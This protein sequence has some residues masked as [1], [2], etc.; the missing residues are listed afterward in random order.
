MPQPGQVVGGRQSAGAGADDEHAPPA[1]GRRGVERPAPLQ[2]EVAEEPLHRVNRDGAV[3]T[4]PV[5]DALTGVVADPPV[6]RGQRIVGDKLPPGLLMPAGLGVRQPGLDVLPGRAARVARWQQVEVHGTAL[7]HRPGSPAP[8]QQVGQRRHVR[9]WLVGHLA[10]HAECLVW[11]R[12]PRTTIPVPARRGQGPT[13]PPQLPNEAGP[14]PGTVRMVGLEPG[15]AGNPAARRLCRIG[16]EG[17]C[18]MTTTVGINGFGR[19]GRAFMRVALERDDLDVV[20]VND[21]TDARTLAHLLE[22]DSTYGPLRRAVEH[23]P[24]SLSVDGKAVRVLSV[25]DPSG[26]DWGELGAAVVVESTGKFRARED[27]ALHL[28]GGARKVVLSAPGK[29]ADLTVVVGVNDRDYD[30]H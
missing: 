19:I 3:Q 21:V 24:T 6:D 7:P 16:C 14:G 4:G 30:P 12:I 11:V 8:V 26:I 25:R 17:E 2:R 10:S 15:G 28:K 22:F 18:K 5:A 23:G 9:W 27:A 29:G 13:A 20:A 1:P